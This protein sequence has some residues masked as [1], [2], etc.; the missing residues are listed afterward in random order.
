MIINFNH[1]HG[2]YLQKNSSI[3]LLQNIVDYLPNLI[4]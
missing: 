1:E 2:S 3:T 4:E